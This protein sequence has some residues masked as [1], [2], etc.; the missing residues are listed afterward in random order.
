MD[1]SAP[2]GKTTVELTSSQTKPADLSKGTPKTQI[3]GDSQATREKIQLFKKEAT[4]PA[5]NIGD[6]TINYWLSSCIKGALV[7][8]REF[9]TAREELL[10]VLKEKEDAE[11]HVKALSANSYGGTTS[12]LQN[13]IKSLGDIKSNIIVNQNHLDRCELTFS[14]TLKPL[15]ELKINDKGENIFEINDP[16]FA[17]YKSDADFIEKAAQLS[18]RCETLNKTYSNKIGEEKDEKLKEMQKEIHGQGEKE[19]GLKSEKKLIKTKISNKG[20]DEGKKWKEIQGKLQNFVSA[21]EGNSDISNV[22][23]KAVKISVN[24]D[25][26]NIKIDEKTLK[27]FLGILEKTQ[28][29]NKKENELNNLKTEISDLVSSTMDYFNNLISK[30]A[31]FL[32]TKFIKSCRKNFLTSFK[33]EF[34]N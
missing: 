31:G 23:K 28:G 1:L 5:E 17:S 20:S 14:A 7:E 27:D 21:S 4:S 18:P 2:S 8:A 3:G 30:E 11:K 25:Q 6:N 19:N 13:R 33:E 34:F 32:G 12:T 16:K 15:L 22:I 10:A 24:Q 26:P 9:M 29:K